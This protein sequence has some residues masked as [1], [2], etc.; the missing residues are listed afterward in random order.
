MCRVGSKRCTLMLKSVGLPSSSG[1]PQKCSS[2]KQPPQVRSWTITRPCHLEKAISAARDSMTL[3]I[4]H[5]HTVF[6]PRQ[7]RCFP[8][9]GIALSWGC[10]VSSL[11]VQLL[12]LASFRPSRFFP[13]TPS[14]STSLLSHLPL[15][16]PPEPPLFCP[17]RSLDLRR[18]FRH[19]NPGR[20]A[21]HPFQLWG[22]QRSESVLGPSGISR[23]L[24]V[25]RTSRS[26]EGQLPRRH[27]R[28]FGN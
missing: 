18:P 6:V 21:G 11:W 27:A 19:V 5:R 14:L 1:A 10:L 7:I 9:C 23:Q 13:P 26:R 12:F 28:E 15:A 2:D 25:S 16:S 4:T 24:A 17:A 22:P 20:T 3:T 8:N